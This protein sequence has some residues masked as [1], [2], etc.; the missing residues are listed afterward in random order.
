MT[1]EI[2]ITVLLE[3]SVNTRGLRAEHGLA[4]HIQFG[5]HRILFNTGQSDLLIPNAR[6]LQLDLRDLEAVVL[7]H[8]HYDHTGGLKEVSELAPHA[9]FYLHPAA[10]LPKFSRQPTARAAR[11]E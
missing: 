1:G 6:A 4:W 7:S 10:L 5:S 8:G 3:N 2:Q 9:R 11:L